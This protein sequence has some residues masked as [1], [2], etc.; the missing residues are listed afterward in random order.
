MFYPT[1]RLVLDTV[2]SFFPHSTVM[3]QTFSKRISY[4]PYLLVLYILFFSCCCLSI[5][6]ISRSWLIMV[7]SAINKISGSIHTN[8]FTLYKYAYYTIP[9]LYYFS[10]NPPFW[11]ASL[12][13]IKCYPSSLIISKKSYTHNGHTYYRKKP[14]IWNMTTNS[15]ALSWRIFW[16]PPPPHIGENYRV[17]T[18]I[19]LW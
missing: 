10:Q 5:F 17:V 9:Y 4:F 19:T 1:I 6:N 2:P 8:L 13:C 16:Y 12:H 14:I 18:V 3:L 11:Y 15:I 7:G